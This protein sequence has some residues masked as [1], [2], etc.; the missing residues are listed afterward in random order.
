[1]CA[2]AYDIIFVRNDWTEI[3]PSYS[4]QSVTK[5][6]LDL[7]RKDNLDGHGGAD[8]VGCRS[9]SAE[10]CAGHADYTDPARANLFKHLGHTDRRKTNMCGRA[11]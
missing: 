5:E 1:M 9:H 3:S 7:S 2:L 4:K 11:R 6:L 10:I 8:A